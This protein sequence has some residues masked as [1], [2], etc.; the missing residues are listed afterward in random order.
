MQVSRW[1]IFLLAILAVSVVLS[2]HS[3][4]AV[5]SEAVDI[6]PHFPKPP[7]LHPNVEFWK[8]VYTEFGAGDFILHDRDNLDVIYDVVQVNGTTNERR[9]EELGKPEVERARERYETILVSLARGIPLEALGLEGRWVAQTWGCPC[10]PEGLLRAASNIRVQQGIREKVEEGLQRARGLL[11]RIL[12]ILRRHDVPDELAALPLVE[13]AFNPQARSRAGAVGLWQFVASTGRRYLTINRGRDDRR[14]PIRATEAAARL[15]RKNY[16]A[17]GSW[18][19]ALMAYHHGMEGVLA[20]RATVGSSAVE[21]IVA[22]YTG[23]RFGFAS[24]NFYAEYL[25]ALEIFHPTIREHAQHPHLPP[26][27]SRLTWKG[28]KPTH[29]F[30]SPD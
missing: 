6:S 18:P 13:S 22:R 10:P 17:L 28:S 15:L 4:A 24:K 14:D 21:E 20:A 5:A 1:R 27:Q 19:L 26:R 8:R 2:L 23:P 12:S 11:P 3:P 30:M 9:A 29:I 7:V 25:A 16:E